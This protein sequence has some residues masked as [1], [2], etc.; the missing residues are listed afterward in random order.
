M[1]KSIPREEDGTTTQDLRNRLDRRSKA[2]DP[3]EV[4][5][6]DQQV[7]TRGNWLIITG[8]AIVALVLLTAIVW[9]IGMHSAMPAVY[10]V[11]LYAVGL[12]SAFLGCMEVIFRPYR[13]AQSSVSEEVARVELG[14]RL[15][16]HELPV[17]LQ[18][19]WYAGYGR[20]H[21]DG[22]QFL[23]GTDG[24]PRNGNTSG[25]VL[26]LR[27]RNDAPKSGPTGPPSR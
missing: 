26:K 27:R 22:R 11:P 8:A 10:A 7:R 6:A 17:E 15:L 12:G 18:Q 5:A 19:R 21:E 4:E 9:H 3:A 24:A 16:I 13:E 25:D 23:T 20:G 1:P 14:L 2:P